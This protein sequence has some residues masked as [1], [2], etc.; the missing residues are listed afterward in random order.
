MPTLSVAKRAHRQASPA[1]VPASAYR[2]TNP[3]SL[4]MSS[5]VLLVLAASRPNPAGILCF[6]VT[7]FIGLIGVRLSC[8]KAFTASKLAAR[9]GDIIG[10]QRFQPSHK[11]ERFSI[12][13]AD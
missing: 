9:H 2:T 7:F 10:G 12:D 6:L 3:Q 13:S 4:W 8:I 1:E 11:R 5:K